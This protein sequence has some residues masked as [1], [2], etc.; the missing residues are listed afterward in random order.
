M[1]HHTSRHMLYH[2]PS[3]PI[4]SH[5]ITSNHITLYHP[6]ASAA[7]TTSP[8]NHLQTTTSTLAS[9]YGSSPLHVH[10]LNV[11][12][13][14]C[15]ECYKKILRERAAGC[16]NNALGERATHSVHAAHIAAVHLLRRQLRYLQISH[17]SRMALTSVTRRAWL[18]HQSRVAHGLNIS[19]AS[20]NSLMR[21]TLPHLS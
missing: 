11:N 9:S 2:I 8:P 21:G 10:T 19:H 14:T 1:L 18:K 15:A 12:P 4:P 13:G 5:H 20:S 17:A 6:N 3:H 7:A 16:Y